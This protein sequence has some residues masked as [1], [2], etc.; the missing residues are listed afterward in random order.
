MYKKNKS[1]ENETMIR[2]KLFFENIL[3]EL[4]ANG[5]TKKTVGK[6]KVIK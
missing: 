4:P 1:F 5:T 3:H 6:T 2:V